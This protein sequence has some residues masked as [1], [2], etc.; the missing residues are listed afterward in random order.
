MKYPA[1]RKK[2]AHNLPFGAIKAFKATKQ[3]EEGM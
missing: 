1:E 3:A 2:N